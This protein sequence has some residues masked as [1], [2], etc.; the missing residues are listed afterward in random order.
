MKK[1]E[2]K[3]PRAL[4]IPPAVKK[5]PSKPA[6]TKLSKS[7]PD[8]YKKIGQI[9]ARKRKLSSQ[10]FSEMARLSHIKP[11]KGRYNGGRK[12]KQHDDE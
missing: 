4:N 2:P 6:K 12:P 5:R 1:L 3:K 7:D 10:D 9:S 8:Y 11:G